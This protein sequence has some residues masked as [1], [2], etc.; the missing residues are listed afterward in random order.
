MAFD[1]TKLI[2]AGDF[3]Y[4]ITDKFVEYGVPE[5]D[6]VYVIGHRAI[7][8]DENDPYTQRVKFFV[9]RTDDDNHVLFDNVY[10]MDPRSIEKV[11]ELEEEEL[12]AI[13]DEDVNFNDVETISDAVN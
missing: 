3:C 12:L 8:E 9:H 6:V 5:G 13:L 4:V 10:I 1:L 7:P 2:K 11:G